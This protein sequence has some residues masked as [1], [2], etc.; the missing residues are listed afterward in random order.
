MKRFILTY[1]LL[2]VCLASFADTYKAFSKKNVVSEKGIVGLYEVEGKVYIELPNEV[3]G[4]RFLMGTMVEACS[5]PL[6]SSAG[7][8]PM[9]PY[10]VCFEKTSSA[11]LLRRVNELN[12]QSEGL[13]PENNISSIL[14]SFKIQE[15]SA[16]STAC[17]IDV[18]SYFVAN[19]SSMDPLDPKAFNAAEGY[20]KRTGTHVSGSSIFKDMHVGKDCFSV[21]V[22]NSYKVKAAFLGVFS[23]GEQA[24]F[25]SQVRRSFVLLPEDRME[26]KE[27]D[28]EVGTYTVSL[29]EYDPQKTGS[30]EKVY[31]TRWRMETDS[32]GAVK[33]PVRFYVDPN[34]PSSWA[35]YIYASAEEWNKALE[36]A[37]LKSAIKV[38]PYPTDDKEFSQSDIRYSC[39]R[40]NLSPAERIVDSRWCDPATGEIIGAGIVVNHGIAEYIKKN[41]MIQTGAGNPASRKMSI[42]EE[43]FGTALKSL[44]L[45]HI[46]HCLG[47]TD[48]MAGSFAYPVD[49]LS[50]PD[51]TKEWGLSSSVMDELPFNF[52][53]YSSEKVDKAVMMIQDTPGKYDVAALGWLYGGKETPGEMFGKRQSPTYFYDPRSMSFDLGNDAVASVE[54]GFEGL[55][56]A[57]EG[58]NGWLAEDDFDYNFRNGLQE[59]ILLQ[60]YEYIKQVFVNVGGIY[61]NPKSSDDQHNS[62]VSVPKDIQR[63]HL[64]WALERIDDLSFLDNEELKANSALRGDTGEF[65]QKYFSNF[66]FVQLDAMWFSEVKSEDPYS[67]EEALADVSAHIWRGAEKGKTPTDIQKFQRGLFIDNLLSWSGVRGNFYFREQTA[68]R[69]VS[70]PDKTHIMYGFLKDTKKL[71]EKAVKKADTEEARSHYQYLLFTV[72]KFI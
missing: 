47:L 18:T 30:K 65:C 10:A 60:A 54:K 44:M 6:E 50:N 56:A 61:I 26:P 4:K 41:L 24:I 69:D 39:I 29:K 1:A 70:R 20:V 68:K 21:S 63:K 57:V 27:A 11:V 49:S 14:K 36:K 72:E 71:L 32:C 66:I 33:Q 2:L 13:E 16:D 64:L 19:D 31:A 5:D 42:D 37:G 23:G 45:R 40:Y 25:T 15:Y 12:V 8:Q 17:L 51:F 62:Y 34:F 46:G 55:A 35:P 38:Q 9:T 52:T 58:I 3:M 43:L 22:S 28:D 53:A 7:Y 48:N 59:V 67:V